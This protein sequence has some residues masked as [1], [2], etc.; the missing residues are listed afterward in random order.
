M[1]PALEQRLRSARETARAALL[2]EIGENVVVILSTHIVD[3]VKDLCPRMAILAG[4]RIVGSGEPLELIAR[5]E[6]RIWRKA[7]AKSALAEHQ[8]AFEVISTRL[9]GGRTLIHVAADQCPGE[10]FEPT[11]AGLE[12]VYFTTLS[13]QRRAA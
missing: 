7:I 8:A 10:G 4:G 11:A 1:T 2:A 9:F 12:D 13:A 5:V 3:D 6:G